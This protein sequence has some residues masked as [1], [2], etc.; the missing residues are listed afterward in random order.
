[1]ESSGLCV[2]CKNIKK[3][4]RGAREEGGGAREERE[5]GKCNLSGLVMYSV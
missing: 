3:G 5:E 4:G 2:D 1:M